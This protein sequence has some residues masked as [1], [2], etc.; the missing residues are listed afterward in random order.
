MIMYYKVVIRV[1]GAVRKEIASR[2][3]NTLEAIGYAEKAFLFLVDKNHVTSNMEF[4]AS[5]ISFEEFEKI[6]LA[7]MEIA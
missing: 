6:R 1:S 7:E 2:G 3:T 4:I 5:R